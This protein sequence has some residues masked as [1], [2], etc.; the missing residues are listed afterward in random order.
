[1]DLNDLLDIAED[2]QQ[3]SYHAAVPEVAQVCRDNQNQALTAIYQQRRVYLQSRL[4]A[5]YA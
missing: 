1:M 2:W 3:L 5:L 4:D